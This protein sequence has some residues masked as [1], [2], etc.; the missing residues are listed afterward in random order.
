LATPQRWAASAARISSLS[1]VGCDMGCP[2]EVLPRQRRAARLKSTMTNPQPESMPRVTL[3]KACHASC[4]G[5]GRRT[6]GETVPGTFRVTR[7]RHASFNAAC[8]SRGA[9]RRG[10]PPSPRGS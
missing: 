9:V 6:P 10:W 8:G 4:A 3:E 7:A 1:N 5:V 2:R